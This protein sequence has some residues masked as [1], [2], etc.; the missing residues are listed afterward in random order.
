MEEQL[1]QSYEDQVL[2]V[3][4]PKDI[5]HHAAK[6]LRIRIDQ[7]LYQH[8]PKKLI[9]DLTHTQFMD[10][11]GLG[12]ILGRAR[13]TKEMNVE[14]V[15]VNPNAATQKILEMAGVDKMIPIERL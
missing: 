11:S 6:P 4:L 9:L 15:L 12:L 10:S 14:Y 13:I 3:K 5:D 1:L 7:L 8:K 2:K